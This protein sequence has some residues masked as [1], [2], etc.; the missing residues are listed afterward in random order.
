MQP[1]AQPPRKDDRSF[2]DWMFRLWKR[3][4]SQSGLSWLLVDKTG[5]NLTDIETRNHA[6]LQNINTASYTH[7]TATNHTDLTDGGD[8]TLHQHTRYLDVAA[9]NFPFYNSSSVLIQYI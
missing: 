5:S 7:L 6:D 8:T 1:L 4:A 2:D 3:I 9:V